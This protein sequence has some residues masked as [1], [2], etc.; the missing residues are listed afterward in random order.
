[1]SK[2]YTRG[3]G[4][5]YIPAEVPDMPREAASLPPEEQKIQI[6]LEKRRKGK[7]VTVV[8][9]LALSQG[10]IK[11]LGKALRVA[12]GTGGTVKEDMIELQGDCRDRAREWL[13]RQ[14]WG[15][16]GGKH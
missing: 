13:E 12:C 5:A 6:A 15:L 10:D 8:S 1:V 7:V 16:R 4:W 11:D 9:G 14:G 2:K 3:E